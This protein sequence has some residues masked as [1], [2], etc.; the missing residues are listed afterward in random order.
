MKTRQNLDLPDYV[1]GSIGQPDFSSIANR[2][3]EM[4]GLLSAQGW[5]DAAGHLVQAYGAILGRI[6]TNNLVS[7]SA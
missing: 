5:D 6:A 3:R 1:S 7:K 2:V 4:A